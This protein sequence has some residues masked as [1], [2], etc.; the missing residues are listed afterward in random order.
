MLMDPSTKTIIIQKIFALSSPRNSGEKL[1]NLPDRHADLIRTTMSLS[2]S[3]LGAT[4]RAKRGFNAKRR[5]DEARYIQRSAVIRCG[6][7]DAYAARIN[8][9]AC[10]F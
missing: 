8:G 3:L 5:V 4:Y 1:S 9:V 7:I 10:D 6:Y 2:G